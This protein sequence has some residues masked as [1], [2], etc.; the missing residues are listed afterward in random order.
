MLG[1]RHIFFNRYFRWEQELRTV[2]L[3]TRRIFSVHIFLVLGGGLFFFDE[4]AE[5]AGLGGGELHD[6]PLTDIFADFGKRPM[7]IERFR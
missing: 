5:N 1:A 7:G 2:S 3:F 4:S 6:R